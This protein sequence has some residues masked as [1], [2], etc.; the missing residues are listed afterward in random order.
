MVIFRRTWTTHPDYAQLESALD[1]VTQ[2]AT[3][4]N[5]FVKASDGAAKIVWME[6]NIKGVGDLVTPTRNFIKEGVVGV[7]GPASTSTSKSRV[8]LFND[9]ILTTTNEKQ[10]TL[11]YRLPLA[12]ATVK[13]VDNMQ[14]IKVCWVF[15]AIVRFR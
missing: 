6:K 12:R 7:R 11:R 2:A 14:S 5:E 4:V 9:L 13:D 3:D 15:F 10:P 8:F 1:G